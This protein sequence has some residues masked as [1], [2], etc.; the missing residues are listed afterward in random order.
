[1]DTGNIVHK[2]ENGNQTKQN[3]TLKIKTMLAYKHKNGGYETPY[4]LMF[5]RYNYVELDRGA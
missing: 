1:M 5:S 3:T 4:H 2:T